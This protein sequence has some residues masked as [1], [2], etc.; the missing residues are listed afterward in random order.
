VIRDEQVGN[1]KRPL[2]R[3]EC[4]SPFPMARDG[5]Y[6]LLVF[7]SAGIGFDDS[8]LAATASPQLTTVRQP[9][10]EMGQVAHRLLID[11]MEGREPNSLRVELAT[12]L[13]VR[14]STA[15]P[16]AHVTQAA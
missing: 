12:T 7:L 15:A 10:A 4:V 5:Y 1:V 16:P 2:E 13:I 3:L 9:F 8:L 11:Q 6:N 14:E